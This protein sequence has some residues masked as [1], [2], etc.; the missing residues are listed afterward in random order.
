MSY[1]RTMG[2]DHPGLFVFLVD[3]SGSMGSEWPGNS[4]SA[5]MIKADFL[6]NIVN[7]VIR[8]IGANAS[9]KR[10]CDIALIG[11][12]GSQGAFNMWKGALAGN[13]WANIVDI[14]DN[15]LGSFKRKEQR[16]DPVE[17]VIDV[18]RKY[19]YWMQATAM[20]ST[21][22]GRAMAKVRHTIQAWLNTANNRDSFPPIVI[23]VTDGVPD[24]TERR[25]AE[26]EAAQIK[27]LSTN[28]GSILLFNI[29]IPDKGGEKVSF[30]VLESDLPTNDAAAS[31][32]F[33]MSSVLPQEMLGSAL[34]AGLD[35]RPGCRLM[36]TNADAG[37]AAKL[38]NWGSSSG[39][40]R[41]AE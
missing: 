23:H 3:C 2:S 22:M 21:P 18:E 37:A 5:S 29:H 8:E 28:D 39:G 24:T 19:D 35:V 17:G 12:E 25:M 14:I 6:A 11:Y 20:G 26:D 7:K 15:P 1:K 41:T 32:L 34:E 31:L 38:I 4:E 36:V 40:A 10:R 30:P 33:E 9:G 16:E 13:D 27:S